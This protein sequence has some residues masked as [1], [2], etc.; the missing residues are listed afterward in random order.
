MKHK[1]YLLLIAITVMLV[2]CQQ[3]TATPTAT[4]DIDNAIVD[5][6]APTEISGM[7]K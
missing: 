4:S 6:P 1:K 5:E 7:R 2:A 3:E